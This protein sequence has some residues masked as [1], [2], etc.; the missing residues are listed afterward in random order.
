MGGLVCE[1]LEAL[2]EIGGALVEREVSLDVGRLVAYVRRN[3]W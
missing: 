2:V 3:G 1:A